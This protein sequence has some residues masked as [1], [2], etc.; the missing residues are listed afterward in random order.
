MSSVSMNLTEV[1]DKL[2]AVLEENGRPMTREALTEAINN[3]CGTQ[4]PPDMIARTFL[5]TAPHLFGETR[6]GLWGLRSWEPKIKYGPVD[7]VRVAPAGESSPQP[8]LFSSSRARPEPYP[9]SI[10]AIL[11][12]LLNH[13][14]PETDDRTLLNEIS[15][16]QLEQ[17]TYR[18]GQMVTKGGGEAS[19]ANT[20][21]PYRLHEQ[22]SYGAWRFP[23]MLETSFYVRSTEDDNFNL[24]VEMV[25]GLASMFEYRDEKI[26]GSRGPVMRARSDGNLPVPKD[27]SKICLNNLQCD[28]ADEDQPHKY[29][30]R[31]GLLRFFRFAVSDAAHS[32]PRRYDIEPQGPDHV[33]IK[34][35]DRSAQGTEQIKNL[36][37]LDP[38]SPS[39]LCR[40]E[41]GDEPRSAAIALR[42]A[43]VNLHL[44]I[45]REYIRAV[46]AHRV[47]IKVNNMTDSVDYPLIHS[48]ILPY[49]KIGVQGA[50]IILPK[51][52]HAERL[53][54]V[55]QSRDFSRPSAFSELIRPVQTNCVLTRSIENP[56]TLICTTFGVYD[57]VRMTPEAGPMIEVLYKN[58]I[59]GFLSQA[60]ALKAEAADA[61]RAN[62]RWAA[63]L[64]R[65]MKA[66]A[67]SFSLD[68]LHLFQWEAIQHRLNLLCG[69]TPHQVSVINAPTGAGKTLVF[70]VNAA[71]HYLFTGERAV[72]IFPTRI[73]NEDMFKRLTRFVYHLRCELPDEHVTGGVFIGSSDPSY[74]A[75]IN[76]QVG[77]RMVQYEDKDGSCPQCREKGQPGMI[78]CQE[79]KGR[80]VGVCEKC[81]HIIDYIFTPRRV[82]VPYPRGEKNIAEVCVYLPS[83][84]I[85]TPD[86]LFYEATVAAPQ[87]VLPL[88]GAPVM[89]CECGINYSLLYADTARE[90]VFKCGLC[91]RTLDRTER[92]HIQAPLAYFVFDEVHSLYGVTATLISY[93]FNLLRQM[94]LEMGCRIEGTFETGTATIA[95]EYDLVETLTRQRDIVTFPAKHDFL[96]YFRVQPHQV[97]YRAL[98]FM[99]V[100]LPTVRS[101]SNAIKYT[102]DG[103]H[104]SKQLRTRLPTDAYDFLLAYIPRK[105]D[106]HIITNDVRRHMWRQSY[107]PRGATIRFLSGDSRASTI[108][109]ILNDILERN[110]NLLTANMVVSLGLD[111]PRLN[112]MLMMGV[113]QSMT[114][115]VQTA[116]RTGRAMVPGHVTVHLLP[117][118]P[119]NEFVFRN[120]HQVLGD[121]EGY[122]DEKPVRPVNPYAADLFLKN[123]IAGLLSARIAQDYRNAFCDRAGAWL[124]HNWQEFFARLLFTVLA[125][126]EDR[127]VQSEVG[128]AIMARLHRVATQLG[129]EDGQIW[130]WMSRQSDKLYSLRATAER[131]DVQIEEQ[132]L[133]QL[134]KRSDMPQRAVSEDFTVEEGE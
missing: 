73:L 98:M 90:D 114:E 83:M 46:D 13:L 72:M 68:R 37:K 40:P 36:D 39:G 27:F 15:S 87:G 113:P 55:I 93:F 94:T 74:E 60:K 130:N 116:G 125:A 58:G 124:N 53:D 8:G 115:M 85:A 134:M 56:Q 92:S 71:L 33:L 123:A 32:L 102:Y 84:L 42:L 23:P 29:F 80:R 70:F 69:V 14:T 18:T 103:L 131:V 99:P 41:K 49:V 51:Q 52:Q 97:R 10:R 3:R 105:Q 95:N 25:Y 96:R 30:R 64:P 109:G 21:V 91:G 35:F 6:E 127:A 9:K 110:I 129:N 77:E 1:R 5:K 63:L 11:M 17:A 133:L 79:R 61:I 57:F 104:G 76:P 62:S 81:G 120:F 47:T 82:K 20:L 34:L 117:T 54:Q 100:G 112:N 19:D 132:S 26:E 122:Y 67:S 12:E 121:V 44:L 101:L 7:V 4:F 2:A 31:S 65:V 126:N 50:D 78:R 88:F 45:D 106:G 89:S 111:I 24:D 28:L 128:N 66:A 119:R 86:K 16:F 59:D 38:Y 75:V 107:F 48:L 43:D 118:N 22:M 108:A